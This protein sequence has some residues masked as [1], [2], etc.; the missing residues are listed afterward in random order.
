MDWL[1]EPVEQEQASPAWLTMERL[2]YLAVGLLAVGLR[3]F[4]LGLRPLNVGEAIQ[5]LAAY[6]FVH[7]AVDVAP[8]GTVPALFTG[9]AL[10]FTLAGAGDFSARWLPALAGVVLVLLPYGLRHRLGR[11]GALAASLLLAISPSAVHFSR[12]LDSAIL[13]AACGLAMVVGLVGY[14]DRRA[15]GYLYLAGAALGLGL[16]AGSGI[17]YLLL[18]FILFGLLL[19]GVERWLGREAGWSSLVEGYRA[20][21]SAEGTGEGGGLDSGSP[22]L[23]A[24]VAAA[25][26]LG[27]VATA[28]VLHPA[29]I[30]LAADLLG[31]WAQGFLPQP[32]GQPLVYPIL[33]LLRYESLILFLGLV[34]IGWW[35]AGR[36]GSRA[37]FPFEAFLSFWTV[38][39]ILLVAISGHRPAGNIL[40]PLVPL[41]LLA[42][43]A[44]ERLWQRLSPRIVWAEAGLAASVALG[45]GVFFYLQV[46]AYGRTAGA[47]TVSVVGMTLHATL[48]YLLLGLVALLLIAGLAA[49]VWAWRGPQLVLAA[50]S[51]AAV[52]ILSLFAFKAMWSLSFAHA[53]DPR[54]LMVVETTSPE[55]RL[56]VDQLEEL[57]RNQ[58]GDAHTLPITVDAAT[59]PVV[60]W[61]LRDFE[62]Q[63]VVDGLSA[64]PDTVAAITLAMADPPIGET[65]RGQGFPLRTHWLPWG[66]WGQDLVR[67]LL[68]TEATQPV[69]DH[70]VV[71]WVRTDRG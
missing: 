54:E 29:G 51:L 23:R 5:S 70:E 38:A 62:Q 53:A 19:Y 33:L 32:G 27:L 65:F 20:A 30:G 37:L 71:L 15:T 52:V 68:F 50:G 8:A 48:T 55:V 18:V 25:A 24:G 28:F 2:A 56:L 64:P 43:R 45:L 13:V 69:V 3:F 47:E 31:A 49:L 59:G 14:L 61:Y 21:R 58:R 10:G 26:V 39:A 36:R 9:N 46:A 66:L 17:Y 12:S 41:A 67:W 7:G 44:V 34:G 35:L 11:G 16:A 4:Q 57:S 1:F 22:L 6:R 63:V 60:D 42:G 40:L